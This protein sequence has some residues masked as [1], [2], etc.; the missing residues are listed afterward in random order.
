MNGFSS[1][2]SFLPPLPFLLMIILYSLNK[3]IFFWF[4]K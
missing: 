3:P 2:L 1:R 4:E